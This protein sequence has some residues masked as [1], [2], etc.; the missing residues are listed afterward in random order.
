MRVEDTGAGFAECDLPH[1]FKRFGKLH[2][3]AEQNSGGIGLG[4]HIVKQIVEGHGGSIT[5]ESHGVGRGSTFS[6]S[7]KMTPQDFA[8]NLELN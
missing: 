2:R 3:T 7:M 6:F 1:L 8:A 4:L 5:A